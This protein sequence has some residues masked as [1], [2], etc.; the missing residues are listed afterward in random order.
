MSKKKYEDFSRDYEQDWEAVVDGD[1]QEQV[2]RFQRK[3]T[4][5][6]KR[7]L[8]RKKKRSKF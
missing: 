8:D 3:D 7:E 5:R 2:D 4:R 6:Q 1:S